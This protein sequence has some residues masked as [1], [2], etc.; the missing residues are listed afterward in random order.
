MLPARCIPIATALTGVHRSQP[1]LVTA[2]T[3]L[4]VVAL[5]AA[6]FS[7]TAL[8]KVPP[9]QAARPRSCSDRE[10]VLRAMAPS[11]VTLTRCCGCRKRLGVA[12][13]GVAPA[14]RDRLTA[15]VAG[16]EHAPPGCDGDRPPSPILC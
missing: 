6:V 16:G 10:S 15:P 13:S 4:G 7:A 2:P 3:S 12:A 1:V 5:A 11:S 8:A 14:T 9:N